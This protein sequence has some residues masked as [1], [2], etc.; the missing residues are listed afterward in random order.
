[1]KEGCEPKKSRTG[2]SFS[3]PVLA[4]GS[5]PKK[6]DIAASAT[7]KWRAAALV[8]LHLLMAAHIVQWRSMGETVSPI[9]PSEAMYTLQTGAINTGFIFFSL[10]IIA[11]LIF[12]RFVCGWGCHVLALQ[13]LCAWLL[14]KLGLTP[15]PF[16]SRVLIYVPLIFALYMFVWPTVQRWIVK[17]A[18]EPVIPHFTNHLIVTDFWATFPPV[19]VAIPFLFVCGFVAVYFL[20]SK[21]FCTYGCPYGG[22]FGVADKFAPGRIRVTDACNSCGHCTATCTSNVVVHYEVKQYGM[23]VDPGCMKCMDCVSVCPNDALYFG[24]GKPSVA[25]KKV[26]A[27]NYS[28]TWTEEIVGAVV[29][30]LSFFAVWDV[31]QIVPMLMAIGIAIVST[32]LFLRLIKL[33]RSSELSFYRWNLRL[34]GKTTIHGWLFTTFA[35]L[36]LGLNAHSGFVRYLESAGARAFESVRLPDE[37][38]LAQTDPRS[39]LSA[40]DQEGIVRGRDSFRHADSIALLTNVQALSKWA[41]LEY[42]SGNADAAVGL[43]QRA[44]MK[45][46]GQSAALS[47][48]YRGAMLNRLGRPSEALE[49]LDRALADQPQMTAAL[50]EKGEALWRSGRRSEAIETWRS[51][52]RETPKVVLANLFAAGALAASGDAG[53]SSEFES[54]GVQ[55]SPEDAYFLWMVGQRLQNIGMAELAEKNF[56]RAIAL[57]PQLRARRLLDVPV[58]R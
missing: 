42:L 6:T 47:L 48:Y 53:T 13:D 4:S 34:Y 41:W 43:L 21:G 50:E 54:R 37:L 1:M 58:K 22:F 40:S 7:S 55:N 28:L 15:K 39:W 19:W 16:R 17:P 12:G 2:R 20:G 26:N 10:A 27:N 45:Q 31:Y 49:D 36:W 32:Y 5:A 8:L 51:A 57:N 23:V 35:V 9:E 18:T 24:F 30:A 11:T 33:F 3:L 52:A 14:K 25:V 44:S 46:N 38:A 56:A 29:F